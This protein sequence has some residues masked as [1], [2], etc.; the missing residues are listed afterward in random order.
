MPAVQSDAFVFFGASGD[1]AYKQVFPALQA[2][3]AHGRLDMPIIGVSRSDWTRDQFIARARDSI[4]THG[5][6]DEQAFAKLAARLQYIS[7]DYAEDATYER[8]RAV[9]GK[10]ARPLHYL[11][12]PPEMF[13]VVIK[14]LSRSGCAEN[15]RIIV[16][17]PFGRDLASA[18]ALNRTLTDFFPAPAIFRIDHYLGKEAVQN[19]LY[20]RFANSLLE[21]IWNRDHVESVQL[22]MA[23]AF[24]VQGRGSFYES[25]GTIRDVVQNH[26][27][28]VISMLAMD[29]PAAGH[30]D[31]VRDAKLKLFK[32]MRQIA[33]DEA[34]RGQ[35]RG[36]RDQPGVRANSQVE[37]F[38]ALR[39]NI[40]NGRWAGVPFYIRAGKEMPVT[41]TE[42]LV[43]LKSPARAIFDATAP[44]QSNYFR[45]RISPDVLVSVGT[46]VKA[47]GQ[48]MVGEAVELVAQRHQGNETPYERLLS[49]ALEGDASLFS[50]FD[51]IEAAWRTVTPILGN[52]VPVKLYEPQSWGPPDAE[53]IVTG[54]GRWHDPL[55]DP[56]NASPTETKDGGAR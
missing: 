39:L 11:A 14:G 18:Q 41:G 51:V 45:F 3:T 1:L 43:R 49:D 25:V 35:F 55:S 50:R 4:D 42:V 17:K 37:T 29:A 54:D 15:A 56:A 46:R 22:T 52:A 53:H 32:A 34:V 23:E 21:P 24:G 9:L 40:D 47:P 19:L 33:P 13:E 10:A 28:Q 38:V 12:V 44:G 48:A 27:L 20:F 8:L 31:A 26:L 36:Y 6:I 16:E 2:I 7:G 5:A 30:P